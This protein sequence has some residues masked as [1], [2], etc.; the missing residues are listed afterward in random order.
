MGV[1][2]SIR[3]TAAVLWFGEGSLIVDLLQ[4]MIGIMERQGQKRSGKRRAKQ[5]AESKKKAKSNI[6]YFSNELAKLFDESF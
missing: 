1:D 3:P 6:S 5:R 2:A 4:C